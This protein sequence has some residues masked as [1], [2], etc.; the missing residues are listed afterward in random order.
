MSQTQVKVVRLDQIPTVPHVVVRGYEYVKWFFYPR[1]ARNRTLDIEARL[2]SRKRLSLQEAEKII[3][4][5]MREDYNMG[6]VAW[7]KAKMGMERIE[8]RPV[9]GVRRQIIKRR[10]RNVTIYRDLRGRFTRVPHQELKVID[11]AKR[12]IMRPGHE[13]R[14]KR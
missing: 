14:V 4:R 7:L 13:W 12:H 2:F 6:K 1:S 5:A 8:A 3:D 9:W 11:K 10:G